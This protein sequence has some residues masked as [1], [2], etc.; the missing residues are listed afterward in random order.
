MTSDHD[1]WDRCQFIRDY[2]LGPQ[3]RIAHELAV[4]LAE[5][6]VGERIEA[7][8]PETD[9]I[10]F[11]A[12]EEQEYQRTIGSLIYP[13]AQDSLAAVEF[14]MAVEEETGKPVGSKEK[15]SFKA[16]VRMVQVSRALGS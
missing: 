13:G 14:L 1:W 9:L 4:R 5:E 15:L 7:L 2:F 6:G 8:R 11:L 12:M 16:L 3:R 10:T